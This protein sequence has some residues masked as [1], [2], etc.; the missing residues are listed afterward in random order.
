MMNTIEQL[1]TALTTFPGNLAYHMI[2]AFAVAGAL[3]SALYLWRENKFPQGLRMLIGL[4]ALLAIRV[5][6]FLGAGLV[7]QGL[8][9]PHAILPVMDRVTTS[10][11]LIVI[12]WLW[13]FPEPLRTADAASGLLGLL[14]LATAALSWVWWYQQYPQT[15]FNQTWLDLGWGM[16]GLALTFLG[17]II[18]M[19]RRPNG[20][21]YGLGMLTITSISYGIHLSFPSLESDFSWSVRLFQLAAYPLLFVLPRRFH[22]PI[23]PQDEVKPITE[24]PPL[25]QERRQYGIQPERAMSILAIMAESSQEKLCKTITRAIGETMLA[26]I[27][28]LI[29][30]PDGEGQI[31]LQCGYDL[32]REEALAGMSLDPNEVPLLMTAMRQM[33]SLRLPA[34]STS[35]DMFNLGQLLEIGNTGYLLASTAPSQ[36]HQEPLFTIVLLS[37]YSNRRWNRE[38]QHN[39]EEVTQTLTPIFLRAKQLNALQGELDKSKQNLEEMKTLLKEKQNE[40]E[41]FETKSKQLEKK[42]Q[43]TKQKTLEK[44]QREE[45]LSLQEAHQKAE[46][47]IARL[48]VENLRLGEMVEDLLAQGQSVASPKEEQLNGELQLALQEIAYLKEQLERQGAQV[49]SVQERDE[50]GIPEKQSQAYT[51]LAQDLRQPL[52]SILG[53]TD[54]LLGESTGI[55]GALQRKFLER[56]HASAQRMN[57][58]LEDMLQIETLDHEKLSLNPEVV[59]LGDIIDKAIADTSEQLR[60]KNISLR[61]DLPDTMPQICVDRDAMGQILL[62]LLENAGAVS[63][64]EGEIFLRADVHEDEEQD[65]VLLQVADQG[66]GIHKDDLPR[67][68]SRLYSTDN[69]P[70]EGVGETGVGLSIVKTL[71]EGHNGRVWVDTEMGTGSTFNILMPLNQNAILAGEE[72]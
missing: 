14:T 39:L 48:Q 10:L 20:W 57:L 28:L 22:A 68:F 5:L 32:I 63:P 34:S 43:E 59:D 6:L 2:L 17:I 38:D 54:L 41:A 9:N 13:C 8:A 56:V 1:L 11:S 61:V 55:L 60:R 45:F 29:Y 53:Y 70:I 12:L 27:C 30:P 42:L 69:A 66:G 65:F 24:S 3:Q 21:G 58:R 19:I 16:Y 50:A 71:T 47:T 72:A 31:Q 26:D 25:L 37:P 67:V 52:S 49:E 4:G 33:Q 40:S 36:E 18:L 23:S 7:Q 15:A 46:N 44:E 35:R 64:K 51:T 62:H